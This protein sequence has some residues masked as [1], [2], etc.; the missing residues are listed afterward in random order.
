M[1]DLRCRHTWSS[2]SDSRHIL[3]WDMDKR[4]KLADEPCL[5]RDGKDMKQVGCVG[6]IAL[7]NI[8]YALAL[9]CCGKA[10]LHLQRRVVE[11]LKYI[12]VFGLRVLILAPFCFAFVRC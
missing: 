6:S 7:R 8:F 9:A 2:L 1:E 3:L 5:G 10:M 12:Y 11:G 4:G